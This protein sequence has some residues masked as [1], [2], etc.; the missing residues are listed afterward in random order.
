MATSR[1]RKRIIK[2]LAQNAAW[3]VFAGTAWICPY[4]G[5]AAVRDVALD[6]E[7][8][9][10]HLEACPAWREFDG[11][12]LAL[13]ELESRAQ[14]LRAREDFHRSLIVNPS[15]Q[16]YDDARRVCPYGCKVIGNIDFLA[17]PQM[18]D[19]ASLEIL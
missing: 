5:E 9:L 17:V 12:P 8:V 15:W 14:A 3:R 1:H 6:D 16:L 2:E 19:T 13:T 11:R 10:A 7:R 18:V 4:C